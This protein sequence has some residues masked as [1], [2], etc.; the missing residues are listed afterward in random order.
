MRDK[1]NKQLTR[2]LG[3]KEIT[4]EYFYEEHQSLLDEV[5]RIRV[6]LAILKSDVLDFLE[7]PEVLPSKEELDEELAQTESQVR[8]GEAE[9]DEMKSKLDNPN[10]YE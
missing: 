10:L 2:S 4:K 8:K 3:K 1:E 7:S 9:L 6:E 5:K